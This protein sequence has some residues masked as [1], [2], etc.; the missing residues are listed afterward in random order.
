MEILNKYIYSYEKRLIEENRQY[1][2]N[3]TPENLENK[4]IYTFHTYSREWELNILENLVAKGIQEKEKLPI[5]A[6]TYENYQKATDEM[7]QSFEIQPLHFGLEKRNH[8]IRSIY[9][10]LAAKYISFVTYGKKEKLFQI[11]YRKIECGDVIHDEIIRWCD[12]AY[13][14]CFDISQKRYFEYL[15]YAFRVIDKAYA[16]FKRNT[17]E[18]FVV[19]ELC[20]MP[21]LV[22]SV[23]GAFGAKVLRVEPLHGDMVGLCPPEKVLYKEIKL[24]DLLQKV[25]EA[26]DNKKISTEK[27]E[28]RFVIEADKQD[29]NDLYRELGLDL[30]K[31]NVFVMPHALNDAPRCACVQTIYDNYNDWFLDTMETIKSI[32]SV[33]WIIK[34]HPLSDF[35]AQGK[36][37][38][39]VFDENKTDNMYWCDKRVSGLEIKKYA[40]CVITCELWNTND[41][42]SKGLLLR[43]GNFLQYEEQRRVP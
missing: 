14:D 12:G 21:G 32:D 37:I 1:W 6:I 13:F 9:R 16:I 29:S 19:N 5:I 31:K 41:Y 36:Y 40:D 26:Q 15:E 42:S 33:N 4:Y 35:Y 30:R 7:D 34:D 18:Y 25:I 2:R 23:A 17:P 11:K 10:F 28:N 43:V 39:K 38:K 3:S 24:A 8:I 20:Y 27:A 22:A